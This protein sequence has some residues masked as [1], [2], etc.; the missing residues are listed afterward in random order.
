M[1]D[2]P[3]LC[4]SVGAGDAPASP[5]DPILTAFAV[6]ENRKSANESTSN[7]IQYILGNYPMSVRAL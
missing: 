7:P 3:D 5:F 6:S 4:T 1:I 2:N